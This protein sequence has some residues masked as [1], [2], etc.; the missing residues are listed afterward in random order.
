MSQP[1]PV[2]GVQKI[3]SYLLRRR[4]G[5]GGMGIVWLAYDPD[6]DRDVAIKEMLLPSDA[7]EA[8]QRQ[9]SPDSESSDRAVQRFLR[10]ARSAAKLSHPNCVAVHHI[11]REQRKLYIVMEFVDGGSF[12]DVF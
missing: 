3:G 8:T 9:G 2:S 5:E 12:A 4:L 6:L 7:A 10:E 11:T 1:P